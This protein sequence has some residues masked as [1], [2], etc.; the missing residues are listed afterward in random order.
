[1]VVA[2]IQFPGS[3]CERDTVNALENTVGAACELVWGENFE[4]PTVTHS[5]VIP[6]GFSF[7][8]Y[9]RCG[10]M[11][12]QSPIMAAVKRFAQQGGP[13]LGICNGFQILCEAHLLPGAL[14]AN[15]SGQFVCDTV[16]LEVVGGG[17]GLLK[18]YHKNEKIRLPIAHHGGAYFTQETAQIALT[19]CQH[20]EGSQHQIAGIFG[21]PKQNILG[22]M[23]HPERYCEKRLGG[24]DGL[25]LLQCLVEG[26][27]VT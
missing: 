10:A 24:S 16:E 14:L 11:A 3:N 5:I 22:L 18:N 17:Q 27:C 4:L 25:R 20:N 6:G 2:V 1:M 26:L 12:A 13:V 15:Q 7:G 9:L 19:Y 21:G 8:D 23:P